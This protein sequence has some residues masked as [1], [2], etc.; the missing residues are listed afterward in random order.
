MPDH[1]KS[2]YVVFRQAFTNCLN[3]SATL[4][5]TIGSGVF[6]FPQSGATAEKQASNYE[7]LKQAVAQ[8]ASNPETRVDKT[9]ELFELNCKSLKEFLSTDCADDLNKVEQTL[10]QQFGTGEIL[11]MRVGSYAPE[12]GFPVGE[13]GTANRLIDYFAGLTAQD[14]V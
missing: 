6:G 13:A 1:A 8:T 3:S 11:T 9:I 4:F 5:Q 14:L 12:N 10:R 2:S 7:A